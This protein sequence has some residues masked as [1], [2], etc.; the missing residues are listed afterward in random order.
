M[1]FAG[2]SFDFIY[3]NHV[4][5]HTRNPSEVLDESVRVLTARGQMY[6]TVVNRIAFRD[7]HYHLRLVNW[8]PRPLGEKYIKWRGRSEKN[9]LA[10]DRQRLSEMHYFTFDRI[11]TMAAQAG[12]RVQDL[13]QYKMRHPELIGR[14][15]AHKIARYQKLLKAVSPIYSLAR[16]FCLTEFNLLLQAAEPLE[17]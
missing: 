13:T 15:V 7:P 3:C 10:K 6:A 9:P 16:P 2:D 5:E 4:L 14:S 17:R 8:M 12:F 1:P 11:E